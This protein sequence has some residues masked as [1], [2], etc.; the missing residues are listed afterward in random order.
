MVATTVTMA[1]TAVHSFPTPCSNTVNLNPTIISTSEIYER[2]NIHQL[3]TTAYP[4]PLNIWKRLIEPPAGGI[5]HSYSI[6]ETLTLTES[7]VIRKITRK[8]SDTISLAES[9]KRGIFRKISET[10]TLS[11]SP[12]R[13]P[14]PKITGETLSLAES[15]VR[16]TKPLGYWFRAAF[17]Y[18]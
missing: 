1:L 4:F 10:L 7:S 15:I 5:L 13:K 6:S 16:K 8:I 18:N 9:I 17:T 3:E 12:V 11:E 14:K 2:Q